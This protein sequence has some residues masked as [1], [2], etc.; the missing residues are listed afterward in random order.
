MGWFSTAV[1]AIC[2]QTIDVCLTFMPKAFYHNKR[3]GKNLNC[4]V[5]IRSKDSC[6][7]IIKSFLF[8]EPGL[9]ILEKLK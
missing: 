4:L 6:T 8:M 5:A 3:G 9:L 7:I 1:I 2:L